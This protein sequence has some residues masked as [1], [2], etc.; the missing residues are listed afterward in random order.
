RR[1]EISYGGPADHPCHGRPLRQI[2]DRLQTQRDKHPGKP[3]A[4]HERLAAERLRSVPPI[5]TQIVAQI[6]QM[7]LDH[8]DSQRSGL[9]ISTIAW[10]KASGASCGRLCPMPPVMV[11]CSYLPENFLAWAL[12]SGCGA[13][14]A[15]PS[16]VIVG[17]LITG[18]SASRFSMSSNF[19]S[20]SARPRRQR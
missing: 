15:S 9:A 2:D 5:F 11:R 4:R 8:L 12:G 13:P 16:S 1:E 19:A 10:A 18:A 20:P 14:L 6:G 7:S 3:E 17:T